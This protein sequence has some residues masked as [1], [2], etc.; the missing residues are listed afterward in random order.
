MPRIPIFRLGLSKEQ[1]E[2][3]KLARYAPRLTLE[4][5]SAG[6]DNLRHDVYL[7]SKFV[8]EMRVQM[9][10]L[11]ARHGNVE[12]LLASD[13]P[14]ATGKKAP[15][16]YRPLN[17]PVARRDAPVADI[18]ILLTELQVAGLNRAKQEGNLA[19]DLLARLAVLKFLRSELVSQFAQVLERCRIMLKGYEGVRQQAALQFREKV[20]AFQVAKRAVLRRAGQELFQT[21]EEIE[22]ETLARVRRLLL[23]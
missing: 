11:V 12:G 14:L 16:A 17:G 10:R 21:L 2:P 1:V 5:L 6:I 7:S 4:G 8:E 9:T 15:A 3:P 19:V 13:T 23:G 18:K 20:A 22:R